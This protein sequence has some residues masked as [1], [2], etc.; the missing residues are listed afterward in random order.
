MEIDPTTAVIAAGIAG[1]AAQELVKKVWNQSEKWLNV[2]F[3]DHQPKAIEKSR[4]NALD[5]L[6]DLGNRISALE[7]SSDDDEAYKKKLLRSL[8]DP[9]FS[10]VLKDAIIASARTNSEIKHRLLA[11]AV[12]EKLI[13]KPETTESLI[14]NK[15]VETIPHLS[16][17]HL[18]LLAMQITIY[19][20]S[21]LIS[22]E[23]GSGELCERYFTFLSSV[24]EN[25]LPIK[26]E[27]NIDIDYLIS[28]SCL[29]FYRMSKPIET[30]LS[31]NNECDVKR[32]LASETGA[33]IE[34]FW[35]NTDNR[36][37]T[38]L[39]LFLGLFALA[40]IEGI[41]LDNDIS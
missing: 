36:R 4:E 18:N 23:F 26:L 14:I 24:A 37:I 22:E 7:K 12:S 3:K 41:D 30:F 21:T 28:L 8:S 2:Y 11:R 34:N 16:P 19:L 9:D 13:N 38:T 29:S 35:K 32:F 39:G 20:G 10:A 31:T 15:A 27:K 6:I 25:V 5:F 40:E 33:K 1:A 17:K